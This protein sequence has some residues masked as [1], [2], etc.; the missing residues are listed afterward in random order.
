MTRRQLSQFHRLFG[1]KSNVPYA[2]S[3]IGQGATA[4]AAITA[5]TR[6]VSGDWW[7][8]IK[9][10]VDST[11]GNQHLVG[12]SDS[13]AG[14]LRVVTGG[15]LRLRD[16]GSDLISSAS[17]AIV[18]GTIYDVKFGRSGSNFFLEFV[19]GASVGTATYAASQITNPMNQLMRFSTTLYGV[20]VIYEVETSGGTYNTLLNG[21]NAPS[22]GTAWTD[23]IATVTATNFTGA[24]DSWWTSYGS[25]ITFS[26][27]AFSPSYSSSDLLT[28]ITFA[29]QSNASSFSV[30]NLSAGAIQF[31]SSAY[32][33]SFAQS[34]LQTQIVFG[35]AS[36]S[37]SFAQSDLQ[38]LSNGFSNTSFS[39]SFAQSELYTQIS[40][41]SNAFG[42]SFSE[43]SFDQ[44]ETKRY[45]ARF[46]GVNFNGHILYRW[47][48]NFNQHPLYRW[49]G[50]DWEKYNA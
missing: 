10:S 44:P 7:V 48:D 37:P 14:S 25:T 9:F 43:S 47:N 2:L 18:A 34:S 16:N 15:I 40:F 27:Q 26:S 35:S 38:S 3:N 17:G 8:R 11:A 32:S 49:T 36:F 5:W 41:S 4:Y 6:P 46:D 33:P 24:T 45:I 12:R 29:A 28:Q 13:T 50:T 20:G 23:G 19:G 31:S 42:S 39:P 22:T 30:A 21:S 1:A